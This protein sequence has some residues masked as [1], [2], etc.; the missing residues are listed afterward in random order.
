MAPSYPDRSD[1]LLGQDGVG[2]RRWRGIGLEA[3]GLKGAGGTQ[4]VV[5]EVHLL[6]QLR[7]RTR[8][9]TR[10]AVQPSK[11]ECRALPLDRGGLRASRQA[12]RTS[13]SASKAPSISLQNVTPASLLSQAIAPLQMRRS[14]SDPGRQQ[15]HQGSPAQR[16]RRRDRPGPEQ[17][18]HAPTCPPGLARVPSRAE[19]APSVQPEARRRLVIKHGPVG[20]QISPVPL[21]DLRYAGVSHFGTRKLAL[22]AQH[23]KGTGAAAGVTGPGTGQPSRRTEAPDRYRSASGRRGLGRRRLLLLRAIA[24]PGPSEANRAGE[25]NR[26]NTAS[27][28]AAKPRVPTDGEE[29]LRWM[30][31]GPAAGRVSQGKARGPGD[32][33]GVEP[34]RAVRER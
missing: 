12:T 20:A 8:R 28:P 16:P 18:G 27:Q 32:Q 21:P 4:N 19:I 1:Q 5:F 2:E 17:Q 33:G 30:P 15:P 29:R 26:R 9:R 11:D 10:R 24:Q 31:P 13:R 23:S 22:E 14:S 6:P 7:L 3:L 25:E 34:P